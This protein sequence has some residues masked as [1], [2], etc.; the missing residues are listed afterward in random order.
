M[1]TASFDQIDLG[2]EQIAEVHQQPTQ[3]KQA[4]ACIQVDKEIDVTI[5]PAVAARHRAEKAHVAGAMAGSQFQDF[6]FSAADEL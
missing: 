5:L 2:A 4:A 6:G 3:V 1:E